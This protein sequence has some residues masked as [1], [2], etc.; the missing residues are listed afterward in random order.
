M[1]SYQRSRYPPSVVAS[2][3]SSQLHSQSLT[4]PK[5]KLR[6]ALLQVDPTLSQEDLAV[7]M[8]KYS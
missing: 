2:R 3:S 7:L 1:P 4:D 5:T 6:E 8:D